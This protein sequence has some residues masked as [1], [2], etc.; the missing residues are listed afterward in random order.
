MRDARK[1]KAQLLAEVVA[2]RQRVAALE[3][4]APPPYVE[5]GGART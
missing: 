3:A 2:L 1:T 5:A 4:L